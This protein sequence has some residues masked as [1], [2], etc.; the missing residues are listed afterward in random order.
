[1]RSSLFALALVA[2]SFSA[3]G[4]TYGPYPD[5]TYTECKPAKP[6]RQ[7][8][9]LIHGNWTSGSNRQANI[10]Q[11]CNAF[12]AKGIHAFNINYRLIYTT[13]WPAMF[14]DIQTAIRWVRSRGF[15]KVGVGGTSAGGTLSLMAGAVQ[16]NNVS[17][18]TDPLSEVLLYPGFSPKADFVVSMSGPPDMAGFIRLRGADAVLLGIPLPRGIAEASVSPL[19]YVTGAM[20]PTIILQGLKDPNIPNWM[21]DELLT[22]LKD[23]GVVY[24]VQYYRGGHVFLG[25]PAENVSACTDEAIE[26][27]KFLKPRPNNYGKCE[28]PVQ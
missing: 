21:M 4:R 15:T 17:P 20:A 14:Q 24:Q 25:L 2:L 6:T 10:I 23:K 5:E 18:S 26:F 3:Q 7:A 1:M 28:G 12:A 9:I 16:A 13:H 11:L 27:A 22:V 8:I 19:T